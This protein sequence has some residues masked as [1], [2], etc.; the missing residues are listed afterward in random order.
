M[1]QDIYLPSQH[2]GKNAAVE[3]GHW[4]RL[5]DPIMSTPFSVTTWF[6]QRAFREYIKPHYIQHTC[7][8]Q[9]PNTKQQIVELFSCWA[10][11]EIK[12]RWKQLRG[13]S[14]KNG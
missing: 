13:L 4:K 3:M 2:H 12:R 6:S 8:K 10:T 14:Q 7:T 1:K 9:T 11:P 5:G